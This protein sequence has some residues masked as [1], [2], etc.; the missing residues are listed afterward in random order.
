MD[1]TTNRPTNTREAVLLKQQQA[2]KNAAQDAGVSARTNGARP[3]ASSPSAP[4]GFAAAAGVV[5]GHVETYNGTLTVRGGGHRHALTLAPD[6]RVT[7]DGEP[8]KPEDI[9]LGDWVAV[10]TDGAGAVRRVDVRHDSDHTDADE[11]ARQAW[12]AAGFVAT[13]ALSGLLKRGRRDGREAD[14]ESS[15]RRARHNPRR[16]GGSR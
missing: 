2:L 4:F 10:T 9:H 15:Q 5:E 7:R 3:P 12:Q 11:A 1:P 8:A 14:D 6:A 13:L 16:T